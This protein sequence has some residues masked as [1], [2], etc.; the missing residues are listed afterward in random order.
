VLKSA[1]RG[2][3]ICF[4]RGAVKT[5]FEGIEKPIEVLGARII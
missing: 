4:N 3:E 1:L 2:I 5:A